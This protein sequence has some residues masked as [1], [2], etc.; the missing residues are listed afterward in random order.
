MFCR[1]R[2]EW[3]RWWRL[4][5]DSNNVVDVGTCGSESVRLKWAIWDRIDE[6]EA[7]DGICDRH[8][9]ATRLMAWYPADSFMM[10]RNDPK[11][12]N[13]KLR[14]DWLNRENDSFVV[15][16]V[17]PHPPPPPPSP[18]QILSN[19]RNRWELERLLSIVP[20]VLHAMELLIAGTGKE[21]QNKKMKAW[22]SGR[23][24]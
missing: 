23:I 17:V 15:V 2:R 5:Y 10:K 8:A 7:A 6:P 22:N 14:S 13:M 4:N 18:P 16:V 12:V 3:A 1:N 24:S 11:C 9:I 19:W 21:K 20:Y